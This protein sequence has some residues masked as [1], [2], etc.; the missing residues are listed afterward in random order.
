MGRGC[1][2]GASCVSAY[3]SVKVGQRNSSS[4]RVLEPQR[5]LVTHLCQIAIYNLIDRII[6]RLLGGKRVGK[7]GRTVRCLRLTY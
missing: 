1:L 6:V 4:I 3:L 2:I 7:W 5:L